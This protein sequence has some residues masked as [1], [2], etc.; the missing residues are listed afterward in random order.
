MPP[1][2]RESSIS[3]INK[4]LEMAKQS[5][6]VA[7]DVVYVEDLSLTA[8]CRLGK[9]ETIERSEG[10]E[11][12]LR[13]LIGRKQAIVSTSDMTDVALNALV[14]RAKSMALAVPED[15]YCGLLEPQLL[16]TNWPSLE[17]IDPEEPKVELLIDW[18]E[19]AE[20]AAR[21][22]TGVTNSEG[23]EGS[24]NNTYFAFATTNGFL[25]HYDRSRFTCS[26]S[27]LAG[28]DTSMERDYDWSSTCFMEDLIKPETIGRRAGEGAVKRLKPR[29]AESGKVPVVY[30]PRVSGGIIRHFC[31][32]IS[33]S[34]ITRGT[35][36][37]K[38]SLNK[39]VFSN[40]IK[41]TDDPHRKRGLRSRPFD[42]EGGT[43]KPLQIIDDGILSTWLLDSRAARQLGMSNTGH[44][45]RGTSSLPTPSPSNLYL[46]AGVC[47]PS[48]LISDIKSGLYITELIGMGVNSVTGDYSRGAA[49]FWIDK[50]EIAWP[51]SELTV[52]GN[53]KDMLASLTPANDLLF[54]FGIDAPTIR[55]EG[56]TVAGQ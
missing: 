36:Y 45:A 8:T 9:I 51:V 49:G 30:H 35:S 32:A 48:Q 27:V 18:A 11:I 38:N 37:L 44:A 55:I 4:L 41:I 56:M 23:G 20:S 50:G 54:Q 33:G 21:E 3:L 47:S 16:S 7:A 46:H 26:A 15:P 53:L 25:G 6:A 2:N 1:N 19:R 13:L 52:A 24:W 28:E 40:D 12:G 5:D 34:A 17:L 29:K 31:D 39:Q 43:T 22:V 14:E 10:K 42:A